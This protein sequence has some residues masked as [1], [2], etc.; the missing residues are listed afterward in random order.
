MRAE[1]T[2]LAPMMLGG[3]SY[4]GDP[5]SVKGGWD[6]ENEIGNTWRRYMAW[7]EANPSRPWAL[8]AGVMYEVHIYGPETERKG[9]FEVFVGEEVSSHALPVEL[10]AKW[11]PGGE[12]LKITLTGGEI[13]GDWWKDLDSSILPARGLSRRGAHLIEAYD[14]RF[15][16]MDRIGESELDIYL[17]VQARP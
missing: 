14:G 2:T 1:L 17:P 3:L 15:K 8:G 7:L 13:S 12:Y 6:S 16:G 9:Y 10:S 11:I 5:L 4:F